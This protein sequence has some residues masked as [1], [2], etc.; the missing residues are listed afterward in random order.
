MKK[1]YTLPL[2]LFLSFG[3]CGYAAPEYPSPHGYINDFAG[4]LDPATIAKLEALIKDLEAKTSTE[5]AVVTV[6]TVSPLPLKTYAVELF[7]RWGIGKKGKNNGVLF[8]VATQDRRVEIEVG[9]G[10]E[11]VLTDGKC[12]EIL[13]R[14]VVPHFKQS[15]WSKG[16][17]EGAQAIAATISNDQRAPTASR[18]SREKNTFP[19]QEVLPV[20]WFA[21][22]V[23][24]I[25]AF[26]LLGH[27]SVI[28]VIIIIVVAVLFF[29]KPPCPQCHRRKFVKRKRSTIL[30]NATYSH[31]GMKEVI[32]FCRAC[33][34]QW[35]RRETIPQLV[36]S[37]SSNGSSWSSGGGGGSSFGGGCSGGGGAGRSF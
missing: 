6:K 28:S 14:H 16:I 21:N 35:T 9:Y 36:R 15:H 22:I 3:L 29:S 30:A 20:S 2:A 25:M 4:A 13:D 33:N 23:G 17:L 11:G 5:L 31:S 18:S 26:G 8:I 32:Y 37:S 12:G 34:D 27:I 10:L 1:R 24:L 19:S 7:K